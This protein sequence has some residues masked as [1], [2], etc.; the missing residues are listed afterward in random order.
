[1]LEPEPRNTAPALA[2]AALLLARDPGALMLVCPADHAIDDVDG[3]RRTVALAAD[4]ADQGR[5]VT[6]GITATS[7]ETGYGWIQ[8]G[9]RPAD[10][11]RIVDEALRLVRAAIS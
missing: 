7:P 10:E 2:V 5:L 6:F 3:F 9:D 11:R 1:M 8:A 4:V